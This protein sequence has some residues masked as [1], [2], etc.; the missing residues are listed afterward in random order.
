MY[1]ILYLSCY[2]FTLTSGTLWVYKFMR[3]QEEF[4]SNFFELY[5]DNTLK[6]DE[7]FGV[8]NILSSIHKNENILLCL[9]EDHNSLV[10]LYMVHKY[11]LQNNSNMDNVFVL[12][13]NN[14]LNR[15]GVSSN[16][17][18]SVCDLHNFNYVSKLVN[19][20]TIDVNRNDVTNFVRN[21]SKKLEINRVFL[22][23]DSDTVCNR[24]LDDI[25]S[26]NF[27]DYNIHQYVDNLHTYKPFINVSRDYLETFVSYN[28]I[29]FCNTNRVENLS[30]NSV[31]N[32]YFPILDIYKKEWRQNLRKFYETSRELDLEIDNNYDLLLE[33]V[34]KEYKYGYILNLEDHHINYNMFRRLLNSSDVSLILDDIFI[35]YK[36]FKNSFVFSTFYKLDSTYYVFIKNKRLVFFKLNEF[37]ENLNDYYST[38]I[39]FE[40]FEEDN[41]EHKLS[42]INLLEGEFYYHSYNDDY[43]ELSIEDKIF[44]H[45]IPL[46]ILQ[47]IPLKNVYT[48]KTIL[49]TI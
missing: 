41:N 31:Y 8:N 29:G 24:M 43:S 13:L 9:N 4:A 38:E 32:N 40:E 48:E 35:L 18:E 16:L 5:L 34:K 3:R 10:L 12:S 7:S 37:L 25:F 42:V 30:M 33:N 14:A 21:L 44:N 45:N 46:E 15:S 26:N 2:L 17:L 49:V 1:E 28:Q 47:N 11:Y 19:M 27:S 36:N 6:Q 22:T 20:D 39:T 23:D